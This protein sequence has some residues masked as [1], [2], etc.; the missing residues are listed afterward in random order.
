MDALNI[1][2]YWAASEVTEYKQVTAPHVLPCP[3]ITCR[4][5]TLMKH[6]GLNAFSGRSNC[7]SRVTKQSKANP[8]LEAEALGLNR[9]KP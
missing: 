2:I 8:C 9:N 1:N 3:L 7:C 5:H 6:L 4:E